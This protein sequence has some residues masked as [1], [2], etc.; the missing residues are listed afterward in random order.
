VPSRSLLAPLVLAV[1]LAG[2]SSGGAAPAAVA[3][4]PS[5]TTAPVPD[6]DAGALTGH[7]AALQDA[8]EA[9]G[10]NRAAGG[11]GHLASVRYLKDRL[12]SAGYRT[13]LQTFPLRDAP[14]S[15]TVN[16]IADWPGGDEGAVLLT[17]GH[18]DSVSEGPGI[19]DNASGAAAVL[20]VAL[21]VARGGHQP[22]RHLRFAWWGGE[23]LGLLGSSAY[24]AGLPE[25]ERTSIAGYLNVDMV[26]SPNAGYFVY[27]GDDSDRTG[28]GPGPAGSARIEQALVTAF[29]ELGVPTE[30]TDFSGRSDYGPFV[31]VGIPAG[32]TF[33]GAEGLKTAAQARK[34]GGKAGAP[35]D[36]CY[37]QACD[38]TANVDRRALDRN[39]DALARA[40]WTL[41]AE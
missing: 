23:E 30:G 4:T 20:E 12:D 5:P 18:L 31:Q 16:L 41:A 38:T 33:T 13:R 27:D 1:L 19:N 40:V 2:C 39:A 11:E 10:G 14:G 15:S 36:P 35:Y 22:R 34:W 26:G 17:G 24:V 8:A 9:H 37:H 3:P 28:A 29:D 32:G 25:K 21:A 7:L 6:L